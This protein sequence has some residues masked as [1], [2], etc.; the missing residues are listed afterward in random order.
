MRRSP[1]RSRGGGEGSPDLK[2]GTPPW[3]QPG[4]PLPSPGRLGPYFFRCQFP[5]RFLNLIFSGYFSILDAVFTTEFC[6]S[7][8][9]RFIFFKKDKICLVHLFRLHFFPFVR[10]KQHPVRSCNFHL[11]H[12]LIS[13]YLFHLQ[14]QDEVFL[15]HLPPSQLQSNATNRLL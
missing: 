6:K 5:H 12:L 14:W 15:L 13:N 9:D 8:Y 10:M 3:P 11:W 2:G 4:L 7:F 1:T